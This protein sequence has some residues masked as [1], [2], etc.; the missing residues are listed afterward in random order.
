MTQLYGSLQTDKVAEENEVC[1]QIARE[2]S[3]F[4]ISDR[5][6][7]VLIYLLSLEL[8]N[9]EWFV[10]ITTTVREVAHDAF[11][12]PPEMKIEGT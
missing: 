12:T 9:R 10:P 11:L 6:R 4:E 7:V 3:R 8:E 2:I 1:R 5:Q